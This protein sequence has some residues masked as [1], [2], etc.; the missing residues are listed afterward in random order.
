MIY[1]RLSVAIKTYISEILPTKS[2]D[3]RNG[4]RSQ[5]KYWEAEL[6][7]Y[8]LNQI[9]PEI[10]KLPTERGPATCNRYLSALSCIFI[11]YYDGINPTSRVKRLKEPRNRVRFLSDSERVRLL[12]ACKKSKSKLLYPVVVLALSSGLRRGELLKLTWDRIDLDRGLIYLIDTKNGDRRM[13]PIGGH[14]LELISQLPKT[15]KYVFPT[16]FGSY[17]QDMN[18][19]WYPALKEAGI[20]NFRFHDLRHSCASLLSMQGVPLHTIAEILGHR[21]IR[22]TL[23]YAHL[24]VDHLRGVLGN[25]NDMMFP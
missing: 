16:P 2:Y 1:P 19:Y 13:V 3:Y 24:S 18:Y 15:C 20:S 8:R 12:E 11:H 5:L 10:I 23:K 25:L 17:Y 6:G 7:E 22:V 9:T 14:A 21:D 4:Q